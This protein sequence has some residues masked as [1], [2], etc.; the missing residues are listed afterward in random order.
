MCGQNYGDIIN[1]N[2][3]GTVSGDDYIGG[4]CGQNC[5]AIIRS[6]NTGIVSGQSKVGGVCGYIGALAT[7]C[8]NAG[9][10]R[11]DDYVGGVCGENYGYIINSSNTGIVSGIETYVGGV[12]GYNKRNI[13]NCYYDSVVYTGKA[14]GVVD[15]GTVTNVEGKTTEQYKSGEV[16]YLL[17][18]DQK[19][20]VWG[21]TLSEEGGDPYPVLGGKKVY[22][23]QYYD[24]CVED[25]N[26]IAYA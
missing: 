26:K 5:S 9:T 19:D 22:Q 12:C 3:T 21:Q 16:A 7:N 15:G 10:V 24:S 2:N 4:V 25:K 8:N 1:C 11:G 17:Q 18:G 23:N 14:I 20:S 13:K 6:N